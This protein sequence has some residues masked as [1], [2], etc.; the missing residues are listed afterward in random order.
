[1]TGLV[2]QNILIKAPDKVKSLTAIAPV[3]ACGSPQDENTYAFMEEA[4]KKNDENAGGIIQMMTGNRYSSEFSDFKVN[5]WRDISK[6]EAR[7]RY[8]EMFTGEDISVNV[9]G[10]T[11]PCLV[12][13]GENDIEAH[14]LK[15]MENTFGKWF[16]NCHIE[17]IHDAGHHP[18]QETPIV[19]LS[20]ISN[21]LAKNS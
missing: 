1:M 21:F 14:N 9:K 2:I 15:T 4:A 18:M 19:L 6:E 20:K 7:V 3:P 16:K 12:V 10:V 5:K 8:L 17:T 13:T 11:T